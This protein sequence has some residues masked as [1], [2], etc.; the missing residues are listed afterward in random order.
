MVT[1]ANRRAYA[2]AVSGVETAQVDAG[3]RQYMLR[4]YNYMGSGL[5]LSGIV[6]MLVANTSARDLFFQSTG[7]GVVGYTGLGMVAVFAPI[8]LILAMSF[9]AKRMNVG[10]LQALYWLFVAL[11]GVGLSVAL[12]AYTGVSVTRVFFITA[13]SFGGLSLY[14][15]LTKRDLSVFGTF[16]MMGLVGL[17]I[18]GVV[19]MFVQSAAL[20]FVYSAVGVLLFAG[21]TAYDT[22][23]IK[24]TYFQVKGSGGED[25]SAIMGAVR[26]YLDFINLFMFL[27]QF[28]GVR[29]N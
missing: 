19:Q 12:L 2:A 17:L 1:E 20:H 11:M 26:L 6:A 4:V 5:L 29:R 14:G 3:L 21:M 23:S 25:A 8:G 22:Q 7:G 15:Y 10:T 24:N 18:A 27:L 16:L 13:I 28:L 9:G